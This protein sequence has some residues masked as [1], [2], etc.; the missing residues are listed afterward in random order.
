MSLQLD[1]VQGDG[2][3]YIPKRGPSSFADAGYCG[4]SFNS[5]MLRFHD[6]NTGP[7]YRELCFEAFPEIR[8]IDPDADV[9]A[10]D[11]NGKQYLTTKVSGQSDIM[12]LVANLN[13]AQVYQL[14]TVQEFA[15]VLKMPNVGEYFDMPLFDQW[16]ASVNATN[17][18]L[19]FTDC[20]D[21]EMPLY[22]GGN[23]SV[24]NLQLSDLDVS[25]TIGTQ[26]LA[27]ARAAQQ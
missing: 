6:S 3:K 20:V 10:F 25:W 16:R 23:D 24:D 11:W 18:Q 7:N 27:Q 19:A 15:A 4:R 1:P 9:L 26:I 22:L 8:S 14:A 12:I 17:S 21:Y 2:D 5:G 13:A